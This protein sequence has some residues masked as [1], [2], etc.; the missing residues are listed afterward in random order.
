VSAAA[1]HAGLES[2][3]AVAVRRDLKETARLPPRGNLL[4]KRIKCPLWI[5]GHTHGDV[6]F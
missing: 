1:A 4:R 5:G 2:E 6:D 3:L